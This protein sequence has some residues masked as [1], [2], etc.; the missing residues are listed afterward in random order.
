MV[1]SA[2]LLT[3]KRFN[4]K[5]QQLALA[6]PRDSALRFPSLQEVLDADRAI[7]ASIFSVKA[8]NKLN[9]RLNEITFYR[10]ELQGLLQ[11]RLF[12]A[13]GPTKPPKR[14]HLEYYD[15]GEEVKKLKTH[16]PDEMKFDESW[17]RKYN[18]SA[19]QETSADIFTFVQCLMP[20]GRFV[21]RSIPRRTTRSPRT[22]MLD[23][24]SMKWIAFR[25]LP[26][27]TLTVV[28]L[29]LMRACCLPFFP[30]NHQKLPILIVSQLA[31]W[32]SL[33]AQGHLYFLPYTNYHV[34]ALNQLPK[35][36]D[37]PMIFSMTKFLKPC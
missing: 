8:E 34:I 4:H 17:F 14:Q 37:F 12:V 36:M 35:S 20:K 5:F 23:L 25:L 2:H 15:E 33:Q 30:M 7:W 27:N 29:N 10:Q 11:P 22:D 3:L 13:G 9:D 1:E 6:V 31:F 18:G 28:K 32:T 21:G 16:K 26:I 24:R 19:N